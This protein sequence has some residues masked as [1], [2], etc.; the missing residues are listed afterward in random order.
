MRTELGSESIWEKFFKRDTKEQW[1]A[2]K[3]IGNMRN[4]MMVSR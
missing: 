3:K 4:R 1:D 2:D